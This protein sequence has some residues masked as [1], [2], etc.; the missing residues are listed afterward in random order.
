MPITAELR[1]FAERY[2]AAWCSQDATRVSAFYSPNGSLCINGAAPAVGRSAIT[3]AAQEFMT[4]F[5]DL[6]VLMDD[7]LVQDDGAVYHW[8]LI[9]T[10]TGPAGTGN[11][12]RISGFEEWRIGADGLV[13]ESRGHFD[14]AEYH[15]QLTQGVRESR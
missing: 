8:T 7:L 12:V 6:Q 5:P 13:V 9:G 14:S 10:H 3:Q 4:A 15:R 11:R 1:N 2:T